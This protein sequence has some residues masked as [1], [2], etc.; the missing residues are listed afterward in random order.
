FVQYVPGPGFE[1]V[2]EASLELPDSAAPVRAGE[3]ITLHATRR[4]GPW[5][6][7]DST[8]TE[9]PPCQQI[10]PVVDEDEVASK[11]RWRVEPEGVAAFNTP[12][13]PDYDRQIRFDRPGRY[14]IRAVSE[15]CGAPFESNAI[16][17]VVE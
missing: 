2:M 14:R 5:V 13:P 6:L 8:M 15:G 16:E 10:A 1:Q 4:S 7:R 17:V 11:V 9:D 3:W 12:G